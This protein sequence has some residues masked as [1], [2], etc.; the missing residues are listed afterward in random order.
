[1]R[2]SSL[3][4]GNWATSQKE[5]FVPVQELK[6]HAPDGCKQEQERYAPD[7]CEQGSLKDHY[8]ADDECSLGWTPGQTSRISKKL[9]CC[10]Q[11]TTLRII[12]E[13]TLERDA[14]LYMVFVD[15][16]KAFHF[17]S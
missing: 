8:R 11:K 6:R 5:K 7:S 17:I 16:E 4:T 10:N 9:S 15:F 14:G 13:H 1:M 3:R 2:R 12:V